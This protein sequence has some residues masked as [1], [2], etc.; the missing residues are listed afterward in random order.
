MGFEIRTEQTKQALTEAD[1]IVVGGGSGLS[2]AAGLTYGGARFERIFKDYIAA[3]GM[4]DMYSAGFYP[5]EKEEQKWGYWAKHILFNRYLPEGLSL[6]RGIYD[7][8][9]DKQHF[10]IT[11]NVDSQFAK[12]GFQPEKIF[13]VQG[14]YGEFQCARGCHQQVY[15]NQRQIAEMVASTDNLEIP[16]DLLP[17]CPVCGE[18]LAV[19]IRV[20]DHFVQEEKWNR[21]AADYAAFLDKAKDRK[22]VFLE[23]G[24][25]YNTPTIIRFPFEQLTHHLPEATLIRLNQDFPLGE[26]LN[27]TKTISFTED[28]NEVIRKL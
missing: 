25:G 14:N 17:I 26:K 7:L 27:R 11:T 9:K 8:L 4:T 15:D 10:V 22:T 13:E 20:D 12:A 19:H 21:L 28:M 1:Y 16:T 6:Y 3:Y 18:A 23:L 5:F 24:V 2:S